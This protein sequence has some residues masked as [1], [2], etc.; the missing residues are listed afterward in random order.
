MSET[1]GNRFRLDGKVALVTGGG[2][3]IGRAVCLALSEAGAAVVVQDINGPEADAVAAEVR[4]VGGKAAVVAGDI[5]DI[6]TIETMLARAR[7]EFGRLDVLVN[8]A[9]IYPFAGFLEMPTETLDRVL[10]IN[11]RAVFL[12]TQMG[13]KAMVDLGNG[14]AIINLASVQAFKPTNPGVSHY[15]TTKAGVVMLTKAAALELAPHNIR[16]NAVAPGMTV[17]PGTQQVIRS[18]TAAARVPLGRLGQ[19]EDVANLILFLAS[20]AADYITGET[21][22]V[23]GGYLLT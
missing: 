17:T 13:G 4:S 11:L 2:M 6:V 12:C 9:G 3:G 7:A 18:S 20:P 14:G 15:D 22:V 1:F 19:P 16:V 5:T 21:V 10:D 8:N 23:D